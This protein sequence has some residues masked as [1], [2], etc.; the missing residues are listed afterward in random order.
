MKKYHLKFDGRIYFGSIE[1]FFH[2][3]WGYLLPSIYIINK[4]DN[5][6][7][8]HYLF[9]SCGPVMDKL[10]RDMM[11]LLQCNFSIIQKSPDTQDNNHTSI[12]IPRWEYGLI[13]AHI[14]NPDAPTFKFIPLIQKRFNKYPALL[15]ALKA[16]NFMADFLL[17]LTQVKLSIL[18]KTKAAT[19]TVELEKYEGCYL[20]LKRSPMPK[21]YSAD[22]KSKVAGYGTS[23]R[24]LEGLDEAEYTLRQ[25]NIPI[26][27]FEPGKYSLTE[28]IKVFESSR[29]IIA[30]RGAEF[31]NLIWMKPE[32]LVILIEPSHHADRTPPMQKGLANILNLKYIEIETTQ[33]LYP[34]LK[35][36][37]IEQYLVHP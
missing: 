10:T 33:G 18:K 30:I 37:M 27:I 23:R 6:A 32:S 28:Q 19:S 9:E 36:E 2:F 15:N 5:T 11:H 16:E 31:A 13:R 21:F 35:P 3:M 12:M 4:L 26:R 8:N 24:S 20:L 29:G 1:H 17:A 7:A 14:L 34:A 22:G 25:K